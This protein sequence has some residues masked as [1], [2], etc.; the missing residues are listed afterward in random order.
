MDNTNVTINYSEYGTSTVAQD[1]SFELADN[2]LMKLVY[3]K[4]NKSVSVSMLDMISDNT[5]LEGS[6]DYDKVNLLIKVLSQL[7]NQI[8]HNK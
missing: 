8:K 7:S 1:I 4:K 5:Q 3:D 2:I 6:L